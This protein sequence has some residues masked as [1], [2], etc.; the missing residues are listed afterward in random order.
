MNSLYSI[1][2]ANANHDANAAADLHPDAD[3][4][5]LVRQPDEYADRVS[6]ERRGK[7]EQPGERRVSSIA[8]YAAAVSKHWPI[9]PA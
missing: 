3:P 7:C 8:D 5:G 9:N 4:I 6:L 1:E 2:S